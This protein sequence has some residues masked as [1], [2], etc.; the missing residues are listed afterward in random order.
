M[1]L[2][3]HSALTNYRLVYTQ[4]LLVDECFITIHAL[5]RTKKNNVEH[6]GR[7]INFLPNIPS[8]HFDHHRDLNSTKLTRNDFLK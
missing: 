4:R 2:L 5:V 3:T 6:I 8:F 7:N 1:W